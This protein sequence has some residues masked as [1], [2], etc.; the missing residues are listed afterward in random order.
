MFDGSLSAGLLLVRVPRGHQPLS[1]LQHPRVPR[2]P[3]LH[4]RR[5]RRLRPDELRDSEDARLVGRRAVRDSEQLQVV[6]PSGISASSAPGFPCPDPPLPPARRTLDASQVAHPAVLPRPRRVGAIDG[7]RLPTLAADPLQRPG[8]RHL[9]RWAPRLRRYPMT[10]RS[11]WWCVV[12]STW[13]W[14]RRGDHIMQPYSSAST[15]SAWSR[16]V[17]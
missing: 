1:C 5:L 15:A 17:S 11:N 16:R 7:Q 3:S 8:V 6:C 12:C 9:S 14:S 4:L 2:D 13:L 10:R